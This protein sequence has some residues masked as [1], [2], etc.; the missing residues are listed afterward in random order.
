[1][2]TVAPGGA[3]L[4]S[5]EPPSAGPPSAGAPSAGAASVGAPSGDA[6]AAAPL[7]ADAGSPE[8]ASAEG[9]AGAPA[10]AGSPRCIIGHAPNASAA[11]S[12][13]KRHH[14]ARC[15]AGPSDRKRIV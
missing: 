9:S 14:H 2:A 5:P 1:M 13:V 11:P 8:E 10:L 12:S 6:L 7:S 4:A 3:E 15:V